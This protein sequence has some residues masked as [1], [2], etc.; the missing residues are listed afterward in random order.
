MKDPAFLFYYQDFAFGTRFFTREEKGAYIDLLLEQADGKKLTL[1]YIQEVL[2]TD[3]DRLWNK[4]QTKFKKENGV[5]YNERL[6]F[7]IARRKKHSENQKN[8]ISKRWHKVGNTDLIPNDKMVIP[9]ETEIETEIEKG[10]SKGEKQ[11]PDEKEVLEYGKIIE[12]TEDESKKFFLIYESQGWKTAGEHPRRFNWRAKMKLYKLE[13]LR[14]AR[15][16][17]IT[18]GKN[19]KGKSLEEIYQQRI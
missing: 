17:T 19:G 10:V 12:L 6:A 14:K 7:E 3:F 13:L 16:E 15:D 8:N 18:T 2:G 1:E 4:L 11:N 9:L 5:F